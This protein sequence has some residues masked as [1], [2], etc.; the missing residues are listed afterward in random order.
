[1]RWRG[2]KG[3]EGIKYLSKAVMEFSRVTE[4]LQ[5]EGG[6]EQVKG[7]EGALTPQYDFPPLPGSLTRCSPAN[8]L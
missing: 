6:G 8:E 1:M 3:G 4:F 7:G 5:K 2:N